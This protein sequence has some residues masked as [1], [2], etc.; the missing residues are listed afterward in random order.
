MRVDLRSIRLIPQIWSKVLRGAN[1]VL[2]TGVLVGE[3]QSLQPEPC[4]NRSTH[5][6]E[7]LGI[8]IFPN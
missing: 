8:T 4:S 1:A 5:D 2:L 6:F 7:N 3:H